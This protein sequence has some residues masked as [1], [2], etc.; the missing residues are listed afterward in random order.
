MFVQEPQQRDEFG[1][2]RPAI[3]QIDGRHRVGALLADRDVGT[4][5]GDDRERHGT[6]NRFRHAVELQVHLRRRRGGVEFGTVTGG[7]P[8]DDVDEGRLV[9]EREVGRDPRPGAGPVVFRPRIG[10]VVAGGVVAVGPALTGSTGMAF[11]PTVSIAPVPS[12]DRRPRDDLHPLADAVGL[13]VLEVR[14][15]DR[16]GE[17]PLTDEVAEH[18]VREVVEPVV[19]VPRVDGRHDEPAVGQRGA[20]PMDGGV[21]PRPRV[22]R[23]EPSREEPS[24]VCRDERLPVVDHA[25]HGRLPDPLLTLL[26]QRVVAGQEVRLEDGV[27]RLERVGAEQ[28]LAV[29]DHVDGEP[30]EPDR[31][32]GQPLGGDSL[33]VLGVRVDPGLQRREGLRVDDEFALVADVGHLDPVVQRDRR[34]FAEQPELPERMVVDPTAGGG[35]RVEQAVER[36]IVLRLEPGRCALDDADTCERS[37]VPHRREVLADP[38]ERAVVVRGQRWLPNVVPEPAAVALADRRDDARRGL[39]LRPDVGRVPRLGVVGRYRCGYRSATVSGPVAAD[40]ERRAVAHRFP[41][42][43]A[44]RYAQPS[45]SRLAVIV[46]SVRGWSSPRFKRYFLL[47]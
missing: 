17:D 24:G 43:T 12:E 13:D 7:Q 35:A 18:V 22:A 41:S 9:L 16:D 14:V 34:E 21:E 25:V 44:G 29:D 5:L 38:I 40:P 26:D 47:L 10:G 36:V 39:V 4:A 31:V 45:P 2:Q 11:T 23:R 28:S 30:G 3:D 33:D 8:R 46:R 15:P 19:G 1:R 6:P 32:L 37:A 20:R 42:R 27:L